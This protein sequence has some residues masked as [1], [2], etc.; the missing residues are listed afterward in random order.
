MPFFG[1]VAVF[2]VIIVLQYGISVGSVTNEKGKPFHQFFGSGSTEQDVCELRKTLLVLK[3]DFDPGLID[4]YAEV[5]HRYSIKYG[6]PDK[7]IACVIWR[8]SRFDPLAVSTAECRGLMQVDPYWHAN[9]LAQRGISSEQL[10]QIENNVDIG[11][12]ILREYFD[13]EKDIVQALYRYVGGR[14]EGYVRDILQAYANLSIRQSNADP[15]LASSDSIKT[16]AQPI[17]PPQN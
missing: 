10:F 13:R 6:F 12:Q 2:C 7:L 11:C 17:T 1:L 3:P 9:K 8:E 15:V 5:I 4:Q 16:V 14:H